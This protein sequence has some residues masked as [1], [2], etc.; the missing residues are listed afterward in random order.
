MK[1]THMFCENMVRS[2]LGVYLRQTM[3]LARFL[4]DGPLHYSV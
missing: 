1:L 2:S 3:M 4:H